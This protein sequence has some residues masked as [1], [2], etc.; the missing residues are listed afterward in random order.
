M[1]EVRNRFAAIVVFVVIGVWSCASTF[2]QTQGNDRKFLEDTRNSYS[3]LRRQ[4]LLEVRAS[5]LPN[6]Q[7]M[8]KDDRQKTNQLLCG[9]QN[10]CDSLLRQI[11]KETSTFP[12]R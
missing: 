10:G 5:I 12:T 8:L 4:G 7:L 2:A 11:P 1:N 3:L 6:W 9:F